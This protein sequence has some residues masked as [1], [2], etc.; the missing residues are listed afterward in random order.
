M[1]ELEV[2]DLSGNPV[3]DLWPLA[4]MHRLGALRLDGGAVDLSPLAGLGSLGTLEVGGAAPAAGTDAATVKF[5]RAKPT[6]S[7]NSFLKSDKCRR[8]NSYGAAS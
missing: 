2:L 6:T 3:S 8:R 5:S 1:T 4:G 7:T